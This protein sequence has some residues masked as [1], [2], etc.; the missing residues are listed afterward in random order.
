MIFGTD[1]VLCEGDEVV[2]A[3]AMLTALNIE[4]K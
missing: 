1:D 4:T 3:Q 2:R